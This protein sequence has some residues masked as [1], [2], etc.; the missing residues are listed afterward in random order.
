MR[1]THT[2]KI[3]AA[4]EARC[5]LRRTSCNRAVPPPQGT[6][7]A[8]VGLRTLRLQVALQTVRERAPESVRERER[9]AGLSQRIMSSCAGARAVEGR[10]KFPGLLGWRPLRPWGASQG[11]ATEGAIFRA[12]VTT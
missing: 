7:P 8:T 5:A 3:F 1:N 2:T 4:K 11:T 9:S 12:A 6:R 10:L